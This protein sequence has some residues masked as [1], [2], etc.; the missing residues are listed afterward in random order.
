MEEVDDF[1]DAVGDDNETLA[2]LIRNILSEN[3]YV[4]PDQTNE[5]PKVP[6]HRKQRLQKSYIVR[7]VHSKFPV[8]I[9][10]AV[11]KSGG[12]DVDATEPLKTILTI[13]RD[14]MG[15][16]PATL[17][18]ETIEDRILRSSKAEDESD[19]EHY[20]RLMSALDILNNIKQSR[21]I[22]LKTLLEF[23]QKDLI[24]DRQHK[25]FSDAIQI[26]RDKANSEIYKEGASTLL[27]EQ[28]LLE[29]KR[30]EDHLGH[31]LRE[32][33]LAEARSKLTLLTDFPH[34]PINTCQVYRGRT[35]FDDRL[36]YVRKKLLKQ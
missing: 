30:R 6:D 33:E 5:A 26:K 19:S 18:F 25:R 1:Y 10:G 3:Q 22:N 9:E 32:L 12:R 14:Y 2:N 7:K 11:K 31:V 21:V 36:V 16:T 35:N 13:L 4:K 20:Q 15:Y 23:A 24:E 27:A 28:E 34:R 17:S 29:K 8:E